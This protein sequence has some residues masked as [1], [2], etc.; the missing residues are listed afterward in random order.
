MFGKGRGLPTFEREEAMRRHPTNTAA[1]TLMKTLVVIIVAAASF[2][3]EAGEIRTVILNEAVRL[4][5]AGEY[6]RALAEIDEVKKLLEGTSMEAEAALL[7]SQIIAFTKTLEKMQEAIEIGDPDG[8]LRTVAS[9]DLLDAVIAPRGSGWAVQ[10]KKIRAWGYY[11]TAARFERREFYGEAD[12]WYQLCAAEDPER[13]ECSGWIAAKP[14]LLQKLY[15]KAQLYRDYQ[16][17]RAMELYRD[18]CRMTD[19]ADAFSRNAQ[20][21]MALTECRK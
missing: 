3:L 7:R 1:V 15:L 6:P 21:G 12:R 13:T 8:I 11:L 19:P 5:A 20:K 10:G 18:I 17:Q 14:K 4:Y 2:L 16:P 9:A